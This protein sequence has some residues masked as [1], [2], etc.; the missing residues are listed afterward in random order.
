VHLLGCLICREGVGL[1][2][3][4]EGDPGL[5]TGMSGTKVEKVPQLGYDRDA[6]TF[7]WHAKGEER[8]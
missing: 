5:A 6:A 7:G 3:E 2:S 4:V 1:E 8:G